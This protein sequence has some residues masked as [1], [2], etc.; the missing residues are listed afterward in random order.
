[1]KLKEDTITI[2]GESYSK[3]VKEDEVKKK[4]KW[5][6]RSHSERNMLIEILKKGL[7]D[8]KVIL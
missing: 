2:D 4:P 5:F 7:P 6:E 3:S 8:L 1:L